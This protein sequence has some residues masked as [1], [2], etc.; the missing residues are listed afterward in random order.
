VITDPRTPRPWSNVI[1][2]ARVGLAV[3]QT[4]S[5]FSWIDNSQLAV[6][7]RWQQDLAEDRSGRFLYLRD[8][9][10]GAI[11]SLAPAPC[12]PAYDAFAC[13]HGLGYTTFE[14]EH[15]GVRARWTLAVDAEETVE[16]WRLRLEDTSGRPRR[17]SLVPFLEWNLGTSPAP[18][19]EFQKLFL[20]T[21][22]DGGAISAAATCGTCRRSAGGTGTAP[23]LRL[24]LRGGAAG[25]DGGRGQGVVP[26][27][28]WRWRRPAALAGGEWPALFGRHHDPIA[29]LR[30][31]VDLAP[32][33][34]FDGGFVLATAEDS[35]AARALATRFAG[36]EAIDA[37]IAG[38]TARWRERLASHRIETP[39]PELDG[40]AN[41]WLRYQAISARIFG[42][43]GYYQQSG[44]YGF[45]DQ[46][47]DSQVWLTIDPPRC[48][49]QI[50]LH[51]AHQFADGSVYHWWHPLSEQGHVTRMTDDLLWL[52]FVTVSFLK[53]TR[54]LLD[55]RRP[56]TLPRRGGG[57][58]RRARSTAPSSACSSARA[59]GPA[60]HRRR[61]LERRP[62]GDGARGTRRI[63]VARRVPGRPARRL[64][65]SSRSGAPSA[66]SVRRGFAARAARATA[67]A[68]RRGQRARVGRVLVSPRHARRPH[69]DRLGAETPPARSS[70]T[71]R[72]GRS[73][74]TWRRRSAP[75]PACAPCARTW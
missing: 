34:R 16:L 56:G 20:E 54:R 50:A 69:L 62:L 59:S 64:G 19:R 71:R 35:A 24:R 4:G 44:A 40:L 33:G 45:R 15:H 55:P 49:A 66:A 67:R 65:R 22:F 41:D 46:L 60:V 39:Q 70:S 29:A 37:A 52:A 23:S 25:G 9:E 12:W 14:C 30:C 38:A 43:A 57:A 26:R 48:R 74:P 42:R 27:P 47:Q 18:R 58:A 68:R 61:R 7:V 11:W 1:A 32:G 2:N 6:L 28:L 21:A 73:S 13:R 5:G 53:E 31:A 10:D 8:D 72:P 3:A 17:L 36:A 51:A 75:P 63:G